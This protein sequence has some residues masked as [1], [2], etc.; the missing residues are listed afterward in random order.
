MWSSEARPT[1]RLALL[2]ALSLL[3]ACGFRPVH[4]PG[5]ALAALAGRVAVQVP[6]TEAGFVL[7]NRLLDRL[8]PPGTA[9]Y[10]LDVNLELRDAGVAVTSEQETTRYTLPGRA[11]WQLTQAA[12]GTLL[13]EGEVESFTG[14]SATGTT[15][16]TFAAADDAE[17]RL[18][19]ALADL[20]VMR[21]IA[22]V[23]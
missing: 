9:E 21:L 22:V 20:I 10:L 19:A 14:Y 17:A 8:G 3:A 18:A 16:S 5:G 12:N 13:A 7:R 15:V 1:R 11:T 23:P 2:G 6:A 4:G